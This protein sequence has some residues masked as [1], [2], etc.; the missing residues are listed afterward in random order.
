[1]NFTFEVSL[2]IDFGVEKKGSH[3]VRLESVLAELLLVGFGQFL[4]GR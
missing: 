3:L 4:L 1:M 2:V